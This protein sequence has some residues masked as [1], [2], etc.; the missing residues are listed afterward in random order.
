MEELEVSGKTV[1][2]AVNKALEQLGLE[3]EQVEVEVL[4]EGRTGLW[5]LRSEEARVRVK[6]QQSALGGL[7]GQEQEVVEMAQEILKN[8][9][10]LMDIEASIEIRELSPS[11]RSVTSSPVVLDIQGEDLGILIGRRGDTLASLQYVVN[12]ILGRK[13]R[14]RTT[15][16]VDVE[17][18]RRRREE[19]LKGLALRMAERVRVTGHSVTLEPM[20]AN[21]RRLVHLALQEYPDIMTQSLGEGEG[22]KVAILLK[23]DK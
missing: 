16:A 2:E 5:G 1:D 22:R 17:G 6:P 20:P 7:E 12:M 3:R 21:E 9:F 15:V 23:R 18:Y 8:L 11:Q 13:R 4:N 19:A 14:L 10:S